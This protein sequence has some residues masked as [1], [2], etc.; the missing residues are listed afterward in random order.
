MPYI[1][2][3]AEHGAPVG[4]SPPR[5]T[6]RKRKVRREGGRKRSRLGELFP[7]QRR[8]SRHPPLFG[9]SG[10]PT[11]LAVGPSCPAF[12]FPRRTRAQG[13]DRS[14]TLCG[15]ERS[16]FARSC[17]ASSLT[18]FARTPRVR[19]AP[20][21]ERPRLMALRVVVASAVASREAGRRR[22]RL[23]AFSFAGLRTPRRSLR[24]QVTQIAANFDQEV[25][26]R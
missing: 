6:T 21:T 20:S 5:S 4:R 8:Q 12:F 11:A 3:C 19:D 26:D 23:G 7:L 9:A 16:Q 17:F 10:E 22:H 24:R 15:K 2:A 1:A 14:L 18:G 25:L 13:A